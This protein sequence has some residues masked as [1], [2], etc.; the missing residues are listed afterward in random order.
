[1]I[2]P[3]IKKGGTLMYKKQRKSQTLTLLVI[4]SIMF[5]SISTLAFKASETCV[6]LD[7]FHIPDYAISGTIIPTS[8]FEIG[9]DA[10]FM[11]IKG[12]WNKMVYLEDALGGTI[13]INFKLYTTFFINPDHQLSLPDQV[14]A[15]FLDA[16]W[17]FRFGNGIALQPRIMPG[18]YWDFEYMNSDMFSI[19]FSLMFI[20]AWN[21]Q[22]SG[23]LGLQ[24]RPDFEREL[25][26]L[27][28]LVCAP[29]DEWRF[30]IGIPRTRLTYFA[31]PDNTL[32][33]DL[34]WQNTSYFITEGLDRWLTLEDIRGSLG[35]IW[36]MANE[37]HLGVE[38]GYVFERSM[39]FEKERK[40]NI[41]HSIF[42][43]IS[44]M[45]FL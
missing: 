17:A 39:E 6:I 3:Q 8:D 28:G 24:V 22:T 35:V 2:T 15:L 25:I 29:S 16:G 26:P 38:V 41:D 23:Y 40:I 31:G 45:T 1:M 34:T 43:I 21:S 10:S 44:V 18:L 4:I 27:I 36:R 37:L 42:G 20:K 5:H 11:E 19:P 9:G 13:D 32:F 7:N 30:E 14:G 33:L 12:D